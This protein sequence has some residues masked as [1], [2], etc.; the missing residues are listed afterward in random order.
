MKTMMNYN[1]QNV[2]DSAVPHI[3]VEVLQPTPFKRGVQSLRDGPKKFFISTKFNTQTRPP[4][5]S[6][7]GMMRK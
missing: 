1:Y 5:N 4:I 7:T 2:M 3:G 6:K